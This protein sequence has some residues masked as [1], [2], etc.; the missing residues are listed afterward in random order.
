M[1]L[2]VKYLVLVLNLVELKVTMRSA[3]LLVLLLLPE[4]VGLDQPHP[5]DADHGHE[6]EHL[7][8]HNIMTKE[9]SALD[10]A[11]IQEEV[12]DGHDDRWGFA[13]V[14]LVVCEPLGHDQKVHV[15]EDA[16]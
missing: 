12:D 15:A 13:L 7:R 14:A 11:S 3:S 2:V 16:Q 8:Y 9:G 10:L 6:Q 4:K 5:R 1:Y